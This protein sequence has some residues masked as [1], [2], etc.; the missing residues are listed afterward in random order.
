MSS[1]TGGDRLRF[2]CK[3]P[4]T[5]GAS[6]P[7]PSSSTSPSAAAAAAASGGEAA[8][9]SGVLLERLGEGDGCSECDTE[10]G[11]RGRD[12]RGKRKGGSDY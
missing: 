11:G 5:Q 9:F 3:L 7:A 12:A 1:A 8:A 10:A 6:A 2:G 4:S